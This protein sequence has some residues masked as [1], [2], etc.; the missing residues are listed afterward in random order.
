MWKFELFNS[1]NRLGISELNDLQ[2]L[3]FALKSEPEY[4]FSLGAQFNTNDYGSF[5]LKSY[6][7]LFKVLGVTVADG[8]VSSF[9]INGNLDIDLHKLFIK[10]GKPRKF[11]SRYDD[12]DFFFFNEN[13]A[14][15]CTISI[16]FG[17]QDECITSV[18]MS[19]N[20]I[21]VSYSL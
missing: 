14:N 1:Y 20:R 19:P 21:Y 3:V 13:R 6:N 8:V 17:V 5:F 2:K 15:Q 11:Y 7:P 10:Y 18:E 9:S 16:R 4:F 12:C